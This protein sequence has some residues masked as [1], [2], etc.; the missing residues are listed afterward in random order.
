MHRMTSD[1][2]CYG[3]CAVGFSD[4]YFGSC[5]KDVQ[6]RVD[7]QELQ[8]PR[9]LPGAAGYSPTASAVSPKSSFSGVCCSEYYHKV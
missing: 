3:A 8:S 6:Q 2:L 9:G 1:Q 5:A 7:L 4:L